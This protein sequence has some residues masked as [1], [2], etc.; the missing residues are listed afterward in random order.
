MRIT[1]ARDDSVARVDL[2]LLAEQDVLGLRLGDLQARHQLPGLR[3]FRQHVA[4]LH[5]LAHLQRH[6]LH[7]AADAGA[8]GELVHLFLFQL[9]GGAQLFDLN[10]LR[11][12]LRLHGFLQDVELLL[13]HLEAGVGLF[14]LG[15][16]QAHVDLGFELG[17][18]QLLFFILVDLGLLQIAL[19]GRR[20]RIADRRSGSAV[21]PAGPQDSLRPAWSAIR[22][23]RRRLP[24][25]DW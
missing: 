16:R 19:R 25:A 15:H 1:W 13:F 11:L 5:A 24:S 3:D 9:V 22:N 17:L 12:D 20:R 21:S 10:L 8:N 6:L 7:A 2:R 23:R 14:P 18:E 4:G